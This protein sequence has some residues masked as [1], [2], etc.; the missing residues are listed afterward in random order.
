MEERR[1]Q[2]EQELARR[3]QE[4]EEEA[5]RIAL[6]REMLRRQYELDTTRESQ[7]VTQQLVHTL[8]NCVYSQHHQLKDKTI[9][10]N[11]L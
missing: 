9:F 4:E 7:K 8:C 3:R 11:L 6:E 10:Y 2:K 1:R 5:R